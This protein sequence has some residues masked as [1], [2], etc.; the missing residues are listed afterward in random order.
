MTSE[1]TREDLDEAYAI[2][3]AAALETGVPVN[4]DVRREE[5]ARA[6]EV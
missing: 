1:H 4:G 5:R 6:A 3:V 2:L